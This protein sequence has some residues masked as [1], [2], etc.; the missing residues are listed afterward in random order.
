MTTT[1]PPRGQALL[2]TRQAADRLGLRTE[3][4]RRLID[5]GDLRAIN[6][7]GDQSPTSVRWRI[8]PADLDAWIARRTRS[9]Q[10]VMVARRSPFDGP[11]APHASGP[12]DDEIA[13]AGER[14]RT[15][16]WCR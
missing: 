13:G 12:C 11:L 10:H 4:V 14:A 7:G 5:R 9:P 16:A 2:T 8:D 15:S 1:P 6:I 3:T